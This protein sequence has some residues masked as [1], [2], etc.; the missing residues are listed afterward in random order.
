M[1]QDHPLVGR[2][3]RTIDVYNRRVERARERASRDY[4]ALASAEVD[5]A[6]RI[7]TAVRQDT[8][9]QIEED[10]RISDYCMSET[11]AHFSATSEN[12]YECIKRVKR[13]RAMIEAGYN[14]YVPYGP[15]YYDDDYDRVEIVVNVAID[16]ADHH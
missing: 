4:E 13:E 12:I 8:W 1:P 11:V 10:G 9:A 5:Y 3:F 2:A 15:S 6:D 7:D 16:G 14:P